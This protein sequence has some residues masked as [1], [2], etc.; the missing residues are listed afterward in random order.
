M[1]LLRP[2]DPPV[3]SP[4]CG[5]HAADLAAIAGVLPGHGAR[6]LAFGTQVSLGISDE[7]LRQCQDSNKGS[8]FIKDSRRFMGHGV[9]QEG[10]SRTQKVLGRSS[11]SLGS[12][13]GSK[14]QMKRLDSELPAASTRPAPT[15]PGTMLVSAFLLYHSIDESR[16]PNWPKPATFHL[17]LP[18]FLVPP[19]E[20]HI[21]RASKTLQ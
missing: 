5:R 17:Y 9:P 1:I 14:S 16:P 2:G 8:E 11:V 18:R 20:C 7:I 19:K 21:P 13:S 3:C 12:A 10:S 4:G 15:M 6:C